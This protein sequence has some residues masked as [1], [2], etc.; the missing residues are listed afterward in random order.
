MAVTQQ[1]IGP[2]IAIEIEKRR[3]PAEKPCVAAQARLKRGVLEGVVAEI[4]IQAGGVTG[5]VGLNDV[6]APIAII[7][8]RGDAHAGLRFAVRAVSHAGF[9]ADFGECPVVVVRVE[10]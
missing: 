4:V 9:D 6:E 2:A 8:G 5:E 3:A 10:R 7:I 1:D